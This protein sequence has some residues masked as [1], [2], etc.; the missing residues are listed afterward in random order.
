M[1]NITIY[2][3]KL[4]NDITSVSNNSITAM[5]QN[6]DVSELD[7]TADSDDFDKL[8]DDFIRKSLEE[9]DGGKDGGGE[10]DDDEVDDER[11]GDD[12]ECDDDECDDD[13]GAGIDKSECKCIEFELGGYV[14]EVPMKSSS[15]KATKLTLNNAYYEEQTLAGEPIVFVSDDSECFGPTLVAYGVPECKAWHHPMVSIYRVSESRPVKQVVMRYDKDEKYLVAAC[16]EAVRALPFGNYFFYLSGVEVDGLPVLY[17]NCDGYCCIPF[18]KVGDDVELPPVALEAVSVKNGS[19]DCALDVSLK[20]DR[21]LDSGYGYTLFLY[22]RNYNLVSRGAT[23]AW[24]NY[25]TRKRKNL[26]AHLTTTYILFGEY[27]LFVLQNGVPRWKVELSVNGGKATVTGV[28]HVKP[29]SEEFLVLHVLEKDGDWHRFRECSATVEMK[30]FFLSTC[31]RTYLNK[32]RVSMGMSSLTTLHHFVYNGGSSVAELG[33]LGSLSRMFWNVSYFDPVD[34]ITLTEGTNTSAPND[35]IVEQFTGCNNKCIALYNLSA[36]AGNGPFVVKKMIDAMSRYSYF[37]VCLIGSRAEVGQFFESFPQLKRYFPENNCIPSGNVHAEDFFDSVVK[38]L[39]KVDLCLSTHAQQLLLGTLL[40]AQG[41]GSLHGLKIADIHDFVKSG[42]IDNFVGRVISAAD[43]DCIADRAYLSTVEA[44]DIDAEK[45]LWNRE[46]CFD[47]SIRQLNAMVGLN[48]VK[49]NIITTFNRLRISAERRRLGLKVKG[50]ECHHMLF[51]GNP[52]TGKTTV[53]KMMGRIYRS[54]GLLS[55]GDVVYVDRSKIVGRYIGD[56]ENNMQRILQEARGNILFIDEAY[57]LCS[58]DSDR[59]DFGYRAIECLLT[60]MAQDDCDMIVIFAGYSK[61]IEMMMRCNQ[62]LSGRF[63]YKFDFADYSADE[64]M[65]IAELKLTQQ[66]YELTAEA[67]DL[68]YKTI[69]ET[70]LNKDWDFCNARWVGHYVDNGII[71]AQCER[72]MQRSAPISRDDYRMINAEDVSAAYAL[73]KPAKKNC[74]IYRGIG[75]T[76]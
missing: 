33:A 10:D 17:K 51:T 62:G 75:F 57:T 32:K 31:Q 56:T 8:L 40:R 38:E 29:F 59:R 52:G 54:L 53:A 60:V 61:E 42:I 4:K 66:D 41:N 68:L 49:Q 6:E 30:E 13:C 72:L 2:N 23:F 65:Q 11:F 44:C 39:R 26:L 50:G 58:G 22:N 27:R 55:K 63:P 67:R 47:D 15:C 18:V 76:A 69:E 19:R 24:D 73:Q 7:F 9:D 43:K 45:I 5:A 48:D 46:D 14:Y 36:L 12:D 3:D 1:E 21:M 25:G 74:K 64:L 71:P 34:C 20:F 28:S 35:R 16:E 70:V 37:Y